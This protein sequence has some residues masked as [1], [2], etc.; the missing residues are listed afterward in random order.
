MPERILDALLACAS[1]ARDSWRSRDSAHGTCAW[2][3]RPDDAAANE[4]SFGIVELIAIEVV[5]QRTS[6]ADANEAVGLHA[7]VKK[8]VDAV[9]VLVG[10]VAPHGAS[11]GHR[12]VGLA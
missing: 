7:M 10:I 4:S 6:A 8:Q 1:P 9:Q 5:D 11:A 2:L 12:V 3:A